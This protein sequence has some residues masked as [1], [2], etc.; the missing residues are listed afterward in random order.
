MDILE[1]SISMASTPFQKEMDLGGRLFLV[2]TA[3]AC[4]QLS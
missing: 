2:I 3:R 1:S 4:D